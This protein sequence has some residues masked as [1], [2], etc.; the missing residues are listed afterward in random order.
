MEMI[1]NYHTHTKRCHHAIGEDEDYVKAAIK[2]GLKTLGF[3]DHS[4][5]NYQSGFKPRMRMELK[6]FE[7]YLKSIRELK[8]KYAD[9]INILVGVEAE[10]FPEYMEWFKKQTSYQ[11]SKYQRIYNT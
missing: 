7:G 5:W 9:K 11:N 2:M 8:V 6:E 3:S 1:A 4:P 10:Y